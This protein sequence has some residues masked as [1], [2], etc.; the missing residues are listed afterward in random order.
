MFNRSKKFV[1]DLF[2]KAK[3]TAEKLFQQG[4]QALSTSSR[5]LGKS[6][7]ILSKINEV[8]TQV[9]SSRELKTIAQSDPSLR[10]VY[11]GA[12]KANNLVGIGSN[13]AGKS[14]QLIDERN[15]SR[16]VGQ[17]VNNGIERIKDIRNDANMVPYV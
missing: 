13:L 12:E 15:Y 6:G 16:N 7:D 2:V 8:G 5:I 17:N 10:K 14:S 9:L 1:N 3:P 4:R 11:N